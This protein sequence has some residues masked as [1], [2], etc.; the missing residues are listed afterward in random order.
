VKV[1]HWRR[2]F[3]ALAAVMLGACTAQPPA[4]SVATTPA[5]LEGSSWRLVQIAMS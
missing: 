4:A 2:G 5:S 1:E 3:V